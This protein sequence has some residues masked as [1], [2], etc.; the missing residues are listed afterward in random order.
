MIA[1]TVEARPSAGESLPMSVPAVDGLIA[2]WR[3]EPTT[4]APELAAMRRRRRIAGAWFAP[5]HAL[6][7]P[8]TPRRRWVLYFMYLP[9]GRMA[10]AHAFTLERLRRLDAGLCIVVASP[11]PDQIPSTVRTAAQAL[12][13]KHFD[14]YDFSAYALGLRQI[15]LHSPGSDVLVM[16]DSVF[17]PFKDLTPLFDHA[18]WEMTG[19]TA[20]STLENHIQS[21]AFLLRSVT[22]G[23]LQHLR[24]ALP[25]AVSYSRPHDV[26][27]LQELQMARV[28][29]A[30]MSV[31]SFWFSP[32]SRRVTDPTLVRPLELLAAGYPFL[33]RSLLTK[34]ARFAERARLLEALRG[35]G[36]PE[37]DGASL[38]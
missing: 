33:K 30:S 27:L 19:F 22:P 21:Y 37:V 38:A 3:F 29:S 24:P 14:G 13:W 23:R 16:N 34:H 8:A 6:L 26:V 36:H 17:G 2:N 10:A 18:P 4:L 15:A 5:A 9:R 32:D 31:G 35:Q 1:G 11:G 12:L 28:A 20:S 25:R 7:V